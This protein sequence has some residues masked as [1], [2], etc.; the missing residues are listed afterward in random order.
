MLR[1]RFRVLP[2]GFHIIKRFGLALA[3]CGLLTAFVTSSYGQA[4]APR[5]QGGGVVQESGDS[6]IVPGIVVVLLFAAA[7]HA[8]VRPSS[9]N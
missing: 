4:N 5:P 3:C 2:M 8:I 7:V 6:P 9:R 1:A